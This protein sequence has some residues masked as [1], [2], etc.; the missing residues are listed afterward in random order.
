M[1]GTRL[2]RERSKY[3][4]YEEAK[5]KAAEFDQ[6]QDANKTELQKATDA[7]AADKARADAAESQLARFEIAVA[8]GLDPALAP[9]LQGATK[10]ELEADADALIAQFGAAPPGGQPTT[11]PPGAG[12]VQN[13]RP[14]GAGQELPEE[15]DPRK[16]AEL[17]PRR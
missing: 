15:T 6:I 2:Q 11:P 9:R 5:R 4:D 16:L 8:K 7:G 1:I 10:A 3:G 13:L 12:V 14:A 17:H